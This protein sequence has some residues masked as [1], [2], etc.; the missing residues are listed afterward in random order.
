LRFP[1][2]LLSI[3]AVLVAILADGA[4]AAHGQSWLERVSSTQ[5]AQPH[6]MTPVV[7]VTPRLEQEFRFDVLH[8]VTPT[9][10]VTNVDN[11][12]GLEV[13]PTRRTEL[14]INLPPYL[15]HEN[16]AA[17]DGWGDASFTVKYRFFSRPEE[18]G[19]AIVT[20]FLA[21]SVPTGTYTNGSISAVVTPTLAGGKGWGWFDVQ[22]TL[23]GTFPVNSVNKLGRTI[24]SN[25]SL[26]AHVLRKLWPE[27]EINSTAW[28]GGTNDGRKQTF[29]TPGLIF[30]RFPIRHRIAFVAGVGFEIAVTHYHQYDHGV[31]GTVRVPF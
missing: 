13:I 20:G 25:T 14:L 21:G 1:T 16:P 4:L 19:N 28:E 17:S 31:I 11:G 23:G 10:D 27:V 2:S 22:S 9:G 18:A 3:A 15:A 5:A 29:V 7:T 8:E 6:W 26:Q 12:K 24:L 30:G